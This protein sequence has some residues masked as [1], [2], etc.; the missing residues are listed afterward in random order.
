MVQVNPMHPKRLKEL[1]GNSPNK[2]DRKDP[3]VIAH[4]ITLGHALTVVIPE[5]SRS[6]SLGTE[7]AQA[8]LY[9]VVPCRSCD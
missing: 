6:S 8:Q 3:K 5:G 2:T 1:Q 7:G 9:K 4:I